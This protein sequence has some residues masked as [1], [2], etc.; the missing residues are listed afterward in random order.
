MKIPN[1]SAPRTKFRNRLDAPESIL[2]RATHLKFEPIRP[3]R[4]G[5]RGGCH[6]FR[7]LHI[8]YFWHFCT[9]CVVHV[10][11]DL[12]THRNIT[13]GVLL[14]CHLF[15]D[16][17]NQ[18]RIQMACFGNE[19]LKSLN[20]ADS[21]Y[22]GSYSSGPQRAWKAVDLAELVF[23][24]SV[25]GLAAYL[26]IS[27]SYSVCLRSEKNVLLRSAFAQTVLNELL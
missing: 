23:V 15:I 25:I 21:L 26:E 14:K 6:R 20:M 5:C 19:I 2:L 18:W 9:V 27:L 7:S 13:L 8:L 11:T 17:S 1:I 24:D 3:R 22:L 10:V 16:S 4:L 12:R